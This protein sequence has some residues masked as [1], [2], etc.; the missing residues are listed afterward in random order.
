MIMPNESEGFLEPARPSAELG[1]AE[2]ETISSFLTVAN[3]RAAIGKMVVTYGVGKPLAAFHAALGLYQLLLRL[4]EPLR[5]R[6]EEILAD[7]GF[8]DVDPVT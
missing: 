5:E 6:V 4:E 7:L 3:I 8:T 1:T 2:K